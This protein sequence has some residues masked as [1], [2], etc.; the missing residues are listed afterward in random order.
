MGLG[1]PHQPEVGAILPEPTAVWDLRLPSDEERS[2]DPTDATEST[3]SGAIDNSPSNPQAT[4]EPI[5]RTAAR[6]KRHKKSDPETFEHYSNMAK[7]E[8]SLAKFNQV[9]AG[10]AG[11]LAVGSTI[12]TFKAYESTAETPF[13]ISMTAATVAFG[14]TFWGTLRSA[15]KLKVAAKRHTVEAA[16]LAAP[17]PN[18]IAGELTGKREETPPPKPLRYGGSLGREQRKAA[19]LAKPEAH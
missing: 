14:L 1:T 19:K 3:H 4:T 15:H 5:E 7:T 17:Q 2:P 6:S 9:F 8:Q 10:A 18:Q 11:L 16:K 12:A 13:A